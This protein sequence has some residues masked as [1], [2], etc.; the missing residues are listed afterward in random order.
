ME[1]RQRRVLRIVLVINLVT[2][3]LMVGAA[4][5]S[6]SSS[7]LVAGL[8]N[9][10]D[11]L[12][13]LLSLAVIGASAAAKACVALVKGLLILGAALAVALQIVYRV[14]DPAVPVF[15]VMGIASLV[16]LAANGVC[17]WLLTPFRRGDIN[18]ASA[19]ECSRNDIFDGT[20]VVIASGAVFVFGAGWPDLVV[21]SGLL[22]LFSRSAV[23]VLRDAVA[24][25]RQ[26]DGPTQAQD[27]VCACSVMPGPAT[28]AS[29]WRG[30]TYYFCDVACK[31]RFDEMPDVYLTGPVD[32]RRSRRHL[33]T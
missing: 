5:S 32:A 27:V 14:L 3:V 10:G 4:W 24:G 8:D 7:V 28:P 21:A 22:F 15:E 20:A 9:L 17:L 29:D 33:R 12:T 19:W 31:D 26:R 6:R 2:F 1:G 18:L 11:A 30:K 16:N 25:L 23:R 13:Y